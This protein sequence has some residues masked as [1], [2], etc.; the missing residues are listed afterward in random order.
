[1]LA[2]R[3]RVALNAHASPTAA[4]VRNG[5]WQNPAEAC[6]A[7]LAQAVGADAVGTFDADAAA[8]T[9]MGDT[10]FVNPMVLG[11]AWQK[12]WIPLRRE[13]LLRAMELNGVA[14]EKNRQAFEWGRQA[15]HGWSRVQALLQPAQVITLQPRL[16][17]EQL[18]QRRVEFLTAYQNAAYAERYAAFVRQVQAA[19]APLG[20]TRLAEVVAQQ[21]F[22]LMAY[23]DEY[24]V[25]RLYTDGAFQ[26]KLA[27][28]FEGDVKLKFHLAPPLLAAKNE[29][30]EL[31]KQAYGAWMWKAFGLLARCKGLRGT[32]FDPFGYT[33]ERRT[34]RALIG[35]YQAL[36]QELLANLR[37]DNHAQALE[38]AKVAEQIK[39]FGHV[40]ERNLH[41]ARAR[42][43]ALMAQWRQPQPTV[44]ASSRQAA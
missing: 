31:R 2:G 35:E 37:P 9:L 40:K 18:L 23:K 16:S 14:V 30:G 28:L 12:G 42:W 3:T 10:L 11:Y 8:R 29:R 5:A 26:Q 27:G 25:A 13:S 4:F 36:I 15:A 43:Q 21:L 32:A 41:A 24:E 22:R 7:S 44:P 38:V 33:A 1:M 34:E 19:E 17:L 20:K 39:G 6:V